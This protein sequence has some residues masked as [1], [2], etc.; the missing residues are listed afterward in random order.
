MSLPP[1]DD[2]SIPVAAGDTPAPRTF[3]KPNL[4]L[5]DPD[6]Y[7]FANRIWRLVAVFAILAMLASGP[8]LVG[9]YWYNARYNTIRAEHD[10]AKVVLTDLKP[11]LE[12][13]S[14]ASRMVAKKAGPS[15]VSIYRP[16]VHGADGQGSGVVMDKEGYVLT[17]L[18]VVE[19]AAGLRVQLDDGR[20]FDASVVGFD[21]A[22]DLAVL[23]LKDASNLLP[24]EWGDS[25]ALELG[26]MVWA[27]GSPFGLNRSITFG[28]VSAKGRNMFSGVDLARQSV[29]QEYLQSD[30]AVNPGNSGGP[31]VDMEGRV[32]GINTAIYGPTYQGVSFAIPSQIARQKFEQLRDKGHVERGYLGVEPQPVPAEVRRKMNLEKGRGVYVS[33]VVRD[34]PASVG[35][36]RPRDVI[37]KWNDHN[38]T[39]PTLLSRTIANTE[40][41]ST[42]QVL[43]RRLERNDSMVE[44]QLKIEVG[45]KPFSEAVNSPGR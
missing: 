17:N 19:N 21:P 7:A 39:D 25:D 8:Y 38:A 44:K 13:F 14:L 43:V 29:Y 6:P 26:D 12:D 24:A 1:S 10:A 41:G 9:Q 27:M 42:A 23:K 40:I 33:D 3:D 37:M 18:H 34:G 11:R 20:D 32:V 2:P 35:G 31:L 16:G 15:V 22:T 4:V 36:M 5:H 45:L 28:I 30:V